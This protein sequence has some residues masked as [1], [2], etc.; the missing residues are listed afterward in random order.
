MLHLFLFGSNVNGNAIT[1][2]PTGLNATLQIILQS[3]QV[4]VTKNNN[5]TLYSGAVSSSPGTKQIYVKFVNTTVGLPQTF[6][7]NYLTYFVPLTAV[8]P[9]YFASSGITPDIS[10][11]AWTYAT[12]GCVNS[13][14]GGKLHITIA[15]NGVT[16]MIRTGLDPG[17]NYL[18]VVFASNNSSGQNKIDFIVGNATDGKMQVVVLYDGTIQCYGATYNQVTGYAY[19]ITDGI[20]H[21]YELTVQSGTATLKIDGII[22]FNVPAQAPTTPQVEWGYWN[23]TSPACSGDLTSVQ[24][25]TSVTAL[26]LPSLTVDLSA[27]KTISTIEI[28]SPW[29]FNPNS[30]MVLQYS[31]DGTNWSNISGYQLIFA[32]NRNHSPTESC[33]ENTGINAGVLSN[34]ASYLFLRLGSDISARYVRVLCQGA[35]G[36]GRLTAVKIRQTVDITLDVKSFT[37]SNETTYNLK[38]YMARTATLTLLNYQGQYS[39][40]NNPA[41]MPDLIVRVWA[42]YSGMNVLVG[43]FYA[44]QWTFNASVKEVSVSMRDKMKHCVNNTKTTDLFPLIKGEDAIEYLANLINIS[45]SLCNLDYTANIITSW[46]PQDVNV[47]DEMQKIAQAM[48][49]QSVYFDEWGILQFRCKTYTYDELDF[50]DHTINSNYPWF[51]FSA[52]PYVYVTTLPNYVYQY[53]V[54]TFQVSVWHNTSADDNYIQSM[55]QCNGFVFASFVENNLHG[56]VPDVWKINPATMTAVQVPNCKAGVNLVTD[57]VNQILGIDNI[58]TP[59]TYWVYNLTT[60]TSTNVG[61]PGSAYNMQ[62]TMSYNG[63]FYA[64]AENGS[65]QLCLYKLTGATWSQVAVFWSP[66]VHNVAQGWGEVYGGVLYIPVYSSDTGYAYLTMYAWNGTTLVT[67]ATFAPTLFTPPLYYGVDVSYKVISFDPTT[68][69]FYFT[70]TDGYSIFGFYY[71]NPNNNTYQGQIVPFINSVQ[72][73]DVVL[74]NLYLSAYYFGVIQVIHLPTLLPSTPQFSFTYKDDIQQLQ[75]SITDEQGGDSPLTTEIIVTASPLKAQAS[76]TVWTY[77]ELPLVFQ[78]GG[79]LVINITLDS[80]CDSGSE[81][82]VVTWSGTPGTIVLTKHATKPVL[83]ITT[84]VGCQIT[85]LSLIAKP[86]NTVGKMQGVA[87][88]DS[89]TI[90]RYGQ[91]QYSLENDYIQTQNL[92]NVIANSFI[93]N[94]GKVLT[95]IPTLQI[96]FTPQIQLDDV[97]TVTELNTG[98]NANY[99]VVSVAHDLTRMITTLKLLLG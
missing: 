21:V 84:T 22:I 23:S 76:T 34:N 2:T 56:Y 16:Q 29:N 49:F 72:E 3:G 92:L 12:T 58:N 54:V 15:G 96:V 59:T 37:N 11:P 17:V 67:L 51:S 65:G 69:Y 89:L 61:L 42:G 7:V 8:I 30:Y 73:M 63:N 35:D 41:I 13:F 44:D 85:A 52:Y 36:Y 74:G 91:R 98:I 31:T 78:N 94:Y 46:T 39:P 9:S 33:I 64:M 81:A 79:S 87:I 50:I 5:I 28:L 53:N 19:L 40:A 45:S 95:F 97:V 57:G 6:Y 60:D 66:S 90:K 77:P 71:Y 18:K 43:T 4:T 14:V 55:V 47:L 48:G 93:Q 10:T 88:T 1:Y 27:I 20:S 25:Q 83:T 70:I 38:Q 82:V 32:S 99:H 75:S 80:P 68:G 86:Y 26:P 24:Y 62:G